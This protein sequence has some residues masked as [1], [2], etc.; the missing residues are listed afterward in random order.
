MDRQTCIADEREEEQRKFV[1]FSR[2]CKTAI[3]DPSKPT[4]EERL[5]KIEERLTEIEGVLTSV[6]SPEWDLRKKV[7]ALEIQAKHLAC[8]IPNV[9][10][11]LKE[12]RN[13]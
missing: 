3:F 1:D 6:S 4:I 9:S 7:E 10:Y 11:E 12:L 8:Y 5:A 13:E 2:Y